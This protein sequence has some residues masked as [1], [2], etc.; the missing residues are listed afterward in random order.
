MKEKFRLF[1]LIYNWLMIAL[2]ILSLLATVIANIYVFIVAIG[3]PN[4]GGWLLFILFLLDLFMVF[5]G[6]IFT[7]LSPCSGLCY[8]KR[9]YTVASVLSGIQ[10]LIAL[11]AIPLS[12]IF[13]ISEPDLLSLDYALYFIISIAIYLIY[14]FA[15]LL[16]L[17]ISIITMKLYKKNTD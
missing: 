1:G 10:T 9:F 3:D 8:I 14:L 16:Q 5:P 13:L 2:Y 11:A 12:A 4:G 7:I 15:S 17:V 6:L